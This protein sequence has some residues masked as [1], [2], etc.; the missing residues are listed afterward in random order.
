MEFSCTFK[1]ASEGD[2]WRLEHLITN[3]KCA[4]DTRGPSGHPYVS[5]HA[6]ASC[7]HTIAI[8]SMCIWL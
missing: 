2:I 8:C 5:Y 6:V 4:V 7:L 1:A 3:E